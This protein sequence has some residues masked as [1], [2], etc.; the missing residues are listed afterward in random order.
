MFHTDWD[1]FPRLFFFN[2]HNTYIVGLDPDFMR[3]KDSEGYKRWKDITR[4]KVRLPARVILQ[5]FGCAYAF[6][7]NKHRKFIALADRD[8]LM[9]KVYS[10][11]YTTVYR[12]LDDNAE[13]TRSSP[14]G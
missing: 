10:D 2:T 11:R 9:E 7:D 14:R 1:D 3:L 5:R 13:K 8:P 4:G 12:V 6:T